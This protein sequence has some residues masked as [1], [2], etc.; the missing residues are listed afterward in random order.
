MENYTFTTKVLT[1]HS[2]ILPKYFRVIRSYYM[3]LDQETYLRVKDNT[4]ELDPLVGLFPVIEREKIF[5]SINHLS[6]S[7]QKGDLIEVT[8]EEFKQ[9]FTKVSIALE[10]L[11]N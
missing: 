6:V 10:A 7:Q 8:E 5:Y 11:M 9:V 1:E 3:I 4:D 2:V